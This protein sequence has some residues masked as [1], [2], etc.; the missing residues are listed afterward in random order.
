MEADCANDR[1]CS[2][3]GAQN[4][5]R[6]ANPG[7]NGN[8][9]ATVPLLLGP[10][11]DVEMPNPHSDKFS[12]LLER[13]A[14]GERLVAVR[15]L[16]PASSDADEGVDKAIGYGVSLLLETEAADGAKRRFVFR[17]GK[18]DSFGHDRRADRAGDIVLAYDTFGLIP[19][20]VP[21]LDVGVME[22]DGGFTSLE[23]EGEFYLVTGYI[24]G[25][26]YADDLKSI[27]RDKRL[28][29][30]DRDRCRALADWLLELHRQ[31]IDQ[32]SGYR[33]AIR[34]LI[35][36]GEGIFGLV[37]NFPADAPGAPLERVQR[38]EA[39]CVEW[40]A[41]LRDRSSRLRRTHGDF[42][43]FNI[44]FTPAGKVAVLDAS[45][46][47]QGDPADDV[48]CLAINYVFFA[49]ENPGSWEAAFR[50]L[51]DDFW[52]RYAD[53][54]GDDQL[55]DAAPPYLAWRTLV[56][57]NPKWYPHVG[58]RERDLLLSFAE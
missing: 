49:L 45:R 6:A 31:K 24:E 33:R 44:L 47:A 10:A 56:M 32:P 4:R 27:G 51:W 17:T 48:V 23:R 3:G 43:P 34:D 54:A 9:V 39:R 37:D 8:L 30:R 19:D 35:G 46:G 21:A 12:R 57:T 28:E 52:R 36:H 18:S 50:T 53:S 13:V 7:R 5:S 38:L 14:P 1:E 40:R 55:L 25:T 41:R 26:P 15:P 58:E 2:T 11:V 29:Q 16:G 20:C 22:P 42:H